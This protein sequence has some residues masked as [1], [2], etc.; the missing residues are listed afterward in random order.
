M[1]EVKIIQNT[2][3]VK[4]RILAIEKISLD[5]YSKVSNKRGVL[6]TCS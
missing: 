6:I 5:Y 4:N 2:V 1:T 3:L